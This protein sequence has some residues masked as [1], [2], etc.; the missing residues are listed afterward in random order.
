MSDKEIKEFSEI[1][2]HGL[3]LAEKRMLKEKAMRGEDLIVSS[4]GKTIQRISAKEIIE[5]NYAAAD[6]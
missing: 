3:E 6:F 1:L 5:S 2:K 4:D